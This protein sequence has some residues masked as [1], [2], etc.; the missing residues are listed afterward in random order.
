MRD[1]HF[2]QCKLL[3]LQ[4]SDCKEFLFS[5]QF[6]NCQL[7]LASFFKLK[8]VGTEFNTCELQET[9]FS[10]ANLSSASFDQCNLTKAIFDRTNLEKADFRT[11][12]GFSINPV[13]NKVRKAKFSQANVIG[14]LGDLGVVVE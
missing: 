10:E 4:F 13:E 14:L 3:G 1:V 8:M 12:V 2:E 11:A 5:V 7:Q 9:D 6:A